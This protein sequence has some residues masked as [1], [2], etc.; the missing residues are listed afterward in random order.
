MYL[1]MLQDK[2]SVYK[3]PLPFYK[4]IMKD[5]K[6]IKIT[7]LFT[8]VSKTIKLL[9]IT[10]MKQMKHL[11]TQNIKT[12]MNEIEEDINK[13]KGIPCSQTSRIDIVK[14]FIFSKLMYK[15][16][17]I[18]IN[19]PMASFTGIIKRMLKFVWNHKILRMTKATKNLEALC[20][21]F[22]NYIH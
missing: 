6:K 3:N 17:T 13:W 10:L 19:I 14:R 11:Y 20:L 18:L 8:I 16:N 12:L 21:L 9:G 1:V 22:S 4:V 7:V 15:F 5:R 2:K